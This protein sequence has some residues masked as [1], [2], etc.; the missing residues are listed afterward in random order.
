MIEDCCTDGLAEPAIT[1]RRSSPRCLQVDRAGSVVANTIGDHPYIAQPSRIVW[2]VTDRAFR[3]VP[4]L[5][6]ALAELGPKPERAS[7]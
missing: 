7:L 1:R 5:T 4:G 6:L 3:S 2:P